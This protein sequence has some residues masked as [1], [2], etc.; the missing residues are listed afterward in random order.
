MRRVEPPMRS[1]SRTVTAAKS[2]IVMN[3]RSG[4]TR[5]SITPGSDPLTM[6]AFPGQLTAQLATGDGTGYSS[7]NSAVGR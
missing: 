2:A 6:N 5:S 1:A 4:R 7:T 3:S